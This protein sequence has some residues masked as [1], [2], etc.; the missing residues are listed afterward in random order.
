MALPR[1]SGFYLEYRRH[2][3]PPLGAY[4]WSPVN[5][6]DNRRSPIK[7]SMNA[8]RIDFEFCTT[9][10][11]FAFAFE[12]IF[13]LTMPTLCSAER[14]LNFP[15]AA[16]VG[17]VTC[18]TLPTYDGPFI[19]YSN[20]MLSVQRAQGNVL[21][22]DDCFVKLEITG[23]ASKDLTF[24]SKLPLD[25]VHS[26]TV[27]DAKLNREQILLVAGVHSL[28][29][30]NFDSCEFS[31][32]AFF[33][34]P[35]LSQLVSLQCRSLENAQRKSPKLEL[36]IKDLKN[37]ERLHASPPLQAAAWQFLKGHP[38]LTWVNTDVTSELPQRLIAL[39]QLPSLKGLNVFMSAGSESAWLDGIGLLTQLQRIYWIGG[40]VDVTIL[41]ELADLPRLTKLDLLNITADDAFCSGLQALSELEDLQI[42]P[43]GDFKKQYAQLPQSLFL[44]PKLKRWPILEMVDE[45]TLHAI[46]KLENIER[47]QLHGSVNV[48]RQ[49]F[50]QLGKLKNLKQLELHH[51]D[52][53]DYW[54]QSVVGLEKLEYLNLWA[55]R[56]NGPGFEALKN[57]KSLRKL[58]I[59]NERSEIDLTSIARL[60]ALEE[61][62][63]CGDNTPAE[64]WP[65]RN[66]TTLKRIRFW[67]GT[68]VDDST[69]AWMGSCPNLSELTMEGGLTDNATRSLAA[70]PAL[71]SLFIES[72]KVTAEGVVRLASI[73]SMHQ[74]IV[75][76]TSEIDP[77]TNEA[78]RDQFPAIPFVLI[79]KN[80]SE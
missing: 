78:I 72:T 64:L 4:R 17:V 44:L 27:K 65:L 30:L 60:P 19:V 70:L 6:R 14:I 38:K 77:K 11:A 55:T 46:C 47:L 56:V 3:N 49:Q 18:S 7:Q 54:L 58:H 40:M 13:V 53:D 32:D 59:Y 45:S 15:A 29:Q 51:I 26:L 37:L 21:V 74:L 68:K 52:V 9:R 5:N 24:L 50:D 75:D 69:A 76:T 8:P 63:L 66:C 25:S 28:T 10:R 36:W 67:F 2:Q 61:F 42:H 35:A 16:P 79:R 39:Q 31:E 73:P 12:L 57:L 34:I 71:H 41:T 33:E 20:T 80:E 22:P 1:P 43:A 48:N 23:R 62:H